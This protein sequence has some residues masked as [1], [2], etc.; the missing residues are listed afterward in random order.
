[1]ERW[2]LDFE[3]EHQLWHM[4]TKRVPENKYWTNI[5]YGHRAALTH[6]CNVVDM[7]RSE[8]GLNFTTAQINRL[9]ECTPGI[10]VHNSTDV[11]ETQFEERVHMVPI[12][13]KEL[14]EKHID[15][16]SIED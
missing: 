6:F 13:S 2:Y 9:A 3:E 8:F 7:M 11:P 4:D 10:R 14:I 1:M 15:W 12:E 5:G 16:N